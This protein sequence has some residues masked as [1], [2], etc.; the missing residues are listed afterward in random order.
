MGLVLEKG[1]DNQANSLTTV[2]FLGLFCGHSSR[3][4]PSVPS[5]IRE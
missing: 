4:P 3:P 2:E 5:K 1:P